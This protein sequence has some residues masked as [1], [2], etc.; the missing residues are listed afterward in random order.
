MTLIEE[1]ERAEKIRN[2]FV[3]FAGACPDDVQDI[4]KAIS[5]LSSLSCV[6]R[7]IENLIRLDTGTGF[8]IIHDDLQYVHEDVT[9]TLGDVWQALGRLGRGHTYQDYQQ[10]WKEITDQA[11][12]ASSGKTLH[13][14][15]EGYRRFLESLS[16]TL[17]R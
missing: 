15:L 5:E 11:R 9:F 16:K 17:D 7:E 12:E 6:L 1:A 13:K 14:T 10:T 4:N 2:A 8:D 3:V